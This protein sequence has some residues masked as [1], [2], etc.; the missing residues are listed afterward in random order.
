M[1]SQKHLPPSRSV[2]ARVIAVVQK[3]LASTRSSQ[4]P[5]HQPGNIG[6]RGTWLRLKT[7]DSAA[8]LGIYGKEN[9]C[10]YP[11]LAASHAAMVA[12]DS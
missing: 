6:R 1:V 2:E 5:D 8:S 4:N 11:Q 10:H 7:D 12:Q 9:G 3:P